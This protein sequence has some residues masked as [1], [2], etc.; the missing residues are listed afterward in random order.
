MMSELGDTASRLLLRTR[1]TT[2]FEYEDGTKPAF[3]E[4]RVMWDSDANDWIVRDN[5]D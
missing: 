3:T 1:Q 4:T 2:L 5:R